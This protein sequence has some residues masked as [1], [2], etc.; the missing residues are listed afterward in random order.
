MDGFVNGIIPK[1]I[2]CRV[3]AGFATAV[4]K[5][6]WDEVVIKSRWADRLGRSFYPAGVFVCLNLVAGWMRHRA[7]PVEGIRYIFEDG[8][9]G[10]RE[11]RKLLQEIKDDPQS[12]EH[13]KMQGF[14]FED[15]SHPDYVPLQAADFLACEAYRQLDNR[16]IEGVKLGRHGRPFPVRGALSC[17]LQQDDPRSA[18]IAGPYPDRAPTPHHG[19]FLD[20]PKIKDLLDGLEQRFPLIESGD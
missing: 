7:S 1:I 5:S 13:Y 11:A 20:E 8:A 3:T 4:K 12:R 10:R 6:V 16:V 17:L 9:P 18:H 19:L 15:K 2:L 14:D